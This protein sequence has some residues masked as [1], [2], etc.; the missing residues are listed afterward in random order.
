MQV[1]EVVPVKCVLNLAA[2]EEERQNNAASTQ[3]TR[4]LSTRALV[5]KCV[6]SSSLTKLRFGRPVLSR[7][8]TRVAWVQGLACSRL[9]Y[10]AVSR[11]VCSKNYRPDK[12]GSSPCPRKESHFKSEKNHSTVRA[13]SAF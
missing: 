1:G 5:C 12:R 4:I 7:F 6:E 13:G 9:E 3:Q 11:G 2:C 8:I 10:C